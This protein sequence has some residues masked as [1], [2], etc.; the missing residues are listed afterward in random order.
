M[1]IEIP[2]EMQGNVIPEIRYWTQAGSQ[3]ADSTGI[4]KEISAP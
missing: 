2:K 3:Q 1:G 4:A